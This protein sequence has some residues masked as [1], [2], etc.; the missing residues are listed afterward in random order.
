MSTTYIC[1]LYIRN[2]DTDCITKNLIFEISILIFP[3]HII[4]VWKKLR[5][6]HSFWANYQ[7]AKDFPNF[8]LIAGFNNLTN[9]LFSELEETLLKN[10]LFSLALV[11]TVRGNISN[12]VPSRFWVQNLAL[13]FSLPFFSCYSRK[14]VLC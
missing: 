14:Y 8:N 11:K 3:W 1:M 7:G 13:S 12:F 9:T 5:K 6:L 2:Y 4:K 10:W